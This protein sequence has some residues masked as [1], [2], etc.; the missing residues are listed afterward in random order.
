MIAA[1][2]AYP[3]SARPTD[4]TA[5]LILVSQNCDIAHH[6][7][8]AEP[9][10]EIIVARPI[11]DENL[12]GSLSHGKNPRR[13]QFRV[14]IDG[15]PAHF[16]TRSPDRLLIDR[17]VLAAGTPD[18][19]FQLDPDT[20]KLLARWLAKRYTRAAFPDGFNER[21]RGVK[22]QIERELKAGGD[23]ITRFYI[24][25]DPYEELTNNQPYRVILIAAAL[26]ETCADHEKES[27]AFALLMEIARLLDGCE[28]V[29]VS[30][31]SLSSEEDVS[32]HDLRQLEPWDFDYLTF[33]GSEPEDLAPDS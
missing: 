31:A 25:L 16:E 33:R 10:A 22:S 19:R 14:N 30:D 9:Y 24:R 3:Q 23:L 11:S 26:P 13:L 27:R 5:L 21:C 15:S 29:E 32:L 8:Q 20:I 1:E 17:R 4:S 18:T 28:G 7:Y 6:S 12:D 2:D